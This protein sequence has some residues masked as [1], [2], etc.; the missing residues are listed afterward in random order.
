VFIIIPIVYYVFKVGLLVAV[1]Y[2]SWLIR[3]AVFIRGLIV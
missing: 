2:T 1:I 3:A